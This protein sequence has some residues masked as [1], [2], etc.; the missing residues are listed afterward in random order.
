MDTLKKILVAHSNLTLPVIGCII[1]L[2]LITISTIFSSKY[3]VIK[4]FKKAKTKA[5]SNLSTKAYVKIVGHVKPT[6]KIL[7][8]PL[9]GKKCI[10]Y[11]FTIQVKDKKNW[12]QIIN[13]TQCTDFFIE[14]SSGI[15]L[16][17]S[18][19]INKNTSVMHI[20][21]LLK[22]SLKP[23]NKKIKSY[24]KTINKK[25]LNTYGILKCKEVIIEQNCK[26]GI[27]GL[28]SWKTLQHTIKGF[29]YSK[30]ISLSGTKQKKLLITDAAKLIA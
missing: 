30:I 7:I 16:I 27:K 9:S 8:A 25:E 18:S 6:N 26:V 29:A 1:I 22:E 20:T 19:A 2:L 12:K 5:I 23:N 11:K 24:L 13:H 21:N 17:T 4:A 15:A 14:D 10:Y 28:T 3:I